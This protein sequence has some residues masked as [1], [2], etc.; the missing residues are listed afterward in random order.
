MAA[1]TFCRNCTYIVFACIGGQWMSFMRIPVALSFTVMQPSRQIRNISIAKCR[2]R[3]AKRTAIMTNMCTDSKAL[4]KRS[5]F[6]KSAR[7]LTTDNPTEDQFPLTS[8]IGSSSLRSMGNFDSHGSNVDTRITAQSALWTQFLMTN[9]NDNSVL[10]SFSTPQATKRMITSTTSRVE[11]GDT[12]DN[13]YVIPIST[14]C[15]TAENDIGLVDMQQNLPQQS[16]DTIEHQITLTD[17]EKELFELL[18]Q[19]TKSC[20][21]PTTLR[22]AGGWVRDKLLATNA[23]RN[24]IGCEDGST[25]RLTYKKRSKSRKTLTKSLVDEDN[26]K[27]VDI[28]IA[29]DDMLGREFAELMN[30]WLSNNGM[31][32]VGIGMVMKNPEKSK[33]LETAT[34]KVGKFWI[35]FV[36]LRAEEYAGDSRIPDLMRIGTAEEDAYRRDLTIN[37]LFY[38]INTGKVEDLTGKG[39]QD[40]RRGIITTPL[41]PLTTLLDDPLRVL[42]SVRF[43]ARLRFS[44]DEALR[45]AARNNLVREAL[46][47]KVSRER[48]G[49]EVD[50]MMRSPDPVGAM[51][52]LVNLN[53]ASTVF[54]LEKLMSGATETS[55]ELFANGISLLSIAHDH[56]CDCK[57]EAP[58]WCTP[59]AISG[60]ISNGASDSM[61]I[62]DERTRKILWYAAFLKPLHDESCQS[63]L[64]ADTENIGRRQGKKSANRSNVMKMIVDELKRPIRDAE[65]VSQIQKTADHFSILIESVGDESINVLFSGARVSNGNLGIPS[66][67]MISDG[68]I[69]II[70]TD[71]ETNSDWNKAMEYRLTCAQILL[72]VGSQWRAALILSLSEKILSLTENHEI[73]NKTENGVITLKNMEMH[74]QIVAQYDAF[75]AS[76]LQL[77]LIGIWDQ[78]PIIDGDEVKRT[79]LKKLPF[80]PVFRQV[81]NEQ[82]EWM[83]LHPGGS[84]SALIFHIQSKFPDHI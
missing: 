35:D 39:F 54:P 21:I 57:D 66:C 50:L 83:T 81:M 47:M 78:K 46:S 11:G 7:V 6:Y 60:M 8:V 52:L 23:W 34:M 80:G 45:D 26:V 58:V 17:D 30:E 1:T 49:S 72:G 59:K 24:K 64:S 18:K 29:L 61:L 74:K 19:V 51:R 28:D 10:S 43:A 36:N 69:T 77:G 44:M 63:G 70:D 68:K 3:V 41:P 13:E 75:A 14:M 48:V 73:V 55:N 76:L 37:S 84:K 38:N 9:S 16:H 5:M 56:L 22:V 15:A 62:N 42:R 82:I 71:N 79:V 53:L 27:P 4:E 33:H 20:E 31:D 67:T 65:V 25:L 12:V 2:T 32:T 40:L